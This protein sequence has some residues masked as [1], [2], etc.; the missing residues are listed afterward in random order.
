MG[1]RV[2]LYTSNK[3]PNRFLISGLFYTELR[4]RTNIRYKLPPDLKTAVR[5]IALIGKY[6]SRSELFSGRLISE[7]ARISRAMSPSFDTLFFC[8]KIPPLSNNVAPIFN[9]LKSNPNL[10]FR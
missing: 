5:P 1:G 7:V 9:F 8:G 4:R 3:L 2:V 6:V 10:F